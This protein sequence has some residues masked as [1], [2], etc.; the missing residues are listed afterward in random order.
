MGQEPGAQHTHRGLLVLQLGLLVLH[1]HHDAGGQVGDPYRGVSGVHRLPSR[2]GGTVDIDLEIVL[3]DLDLLGLVH[4]RQHQHPG[5]RGVDTALGLRLRDALNAVH[6]ALKLQ[7]R[8]DTLSRIGG[9]G[10]H[11][12]LNVF[13]A[14]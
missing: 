9:I 4:L 3:G 5:G 6:P 7:M 11:R 13:V 10:L 14:A 12:H 8:I 1:G 2:T